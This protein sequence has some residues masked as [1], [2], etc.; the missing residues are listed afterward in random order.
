MTDKKEP[1]LEQLVNAD[2]PLVNKIDLIEK[3]FLVKHI[4]P[5][6]LSKHGYAKT[7]IIKIGN[8]YKFFF[9]S[10]QSALDNEGVID[11]NVTLR[12]KESPNAV[13]P[14]YVYGSIQKEKKNF[15]RKPLKY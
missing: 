11:Q 7:V 3:P 10:S 6:F 14:Y 8:E 9:I 5:E 4:S 1:T 12:M 13:K 15:E 2:L